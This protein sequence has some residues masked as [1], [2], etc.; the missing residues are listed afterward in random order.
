MAIYSFERKIVSRSQPAQGK[1]KSPGQQPSV[2]ARSAYISG[3]KLRDERI[4]KD[5]DYRRK[6][7][8]IVGKGIALPEGAPEWMAEREKLWNAVEK[9]EKRKDSQLAFSY[10]ITLPREFSRE[11][12]VKLIEDWCEKRREK[13]FVC[14]WGLHNEKASDGGEQPHAHILVTTRPVDAEAASGFGKKPDTAGKFSGRG[15]VGKGGKDDLKAERQAWE[16]QCNGALEAAG[17]GERIDCRS[18]KDQGI[19]RLPEPKIGPAANAMRKRGEATRRG[20]RWQVVEAV[21]AGADWG[22]V[23][24][25]ISSARASEKLPQE[26]DGGEARRTVYERTFEIRR[27]TAKEIESD[28]QLPPGAERLNW[29]ERSARQRERDREPER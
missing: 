17:I 3:E 27:E 20:D 7:K 28:G 14:D 11:Q 29:Q 25:A 9:V 24:K 21:N 2:V 5:F 10:R 1:S 26:D 8:G 16:E 22:K 19:E 13:G 15:A 12:Q 23:E 18:L 4:E 6:Q